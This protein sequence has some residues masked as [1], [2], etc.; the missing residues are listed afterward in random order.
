M[1]CSKNLFSMYAK[2]RGSY[3]NL[4]ERDLKDKSIVGIIVDYFKDYTVVNDV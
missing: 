3:R 1:L 2:I 4:S